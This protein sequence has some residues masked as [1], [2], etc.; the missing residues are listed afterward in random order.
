ML[1]DIDYIL[2]LIARVHNNEV[3]QLTSKNDLFE[4]IIPWKYDHIFHA[5]KL[6]SKPR[7]ADYFGLAISTGISS[8]NTKIVLGNV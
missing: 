6:L 3:S 5:I 8:H 1:I 4:Y 7:A 2:S